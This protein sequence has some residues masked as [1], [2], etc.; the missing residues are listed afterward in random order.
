[1]KTKQILLLVVFIP[2]AIIFASCSFFTTMNAEDASGDAEAIQSMIPG[3]DASLSLYQTPEGTK[4]FGPWAASG[5]PDLTP[6]EYYTTYLSGDFARYPASGYISDYYGTQGYQAY[7]EL[8]TVSDGWGD[9]QVKLYIYPTL[10]PEVDYTVETYRV[11]GDSWD[12]VDSSGNAD[13]T[14]FESIQTV[15]FDGRVETR[16]VE[17]T[18]YVDDMVFK[19]SEFAIPDDPSTLPDPPSSMSA[20]T[21]PAKEAAVSG[22]GQYSSTTVSTIPGTAESGYVSTQAKEFYAELSDGNKYSKSYVFT[23]LTSLGIDSTTSTIRVY[24]EDSSGNKQIRSKSS[25]SFNWGSLSWTTTGTEKIDITVDASGVTTY[26]SIT[27]KTTGSSW[28]Q[29]EITLTE[30]S[31]NSNT[32]SGTETITTSSGGSTTYTLTL[33]MNGL[34]TKDSNGNTVVNYPLSDITANPLIDIYLSSGG[35][36]KGKKIGRIL[37]GIYTSKGGKQATFI[38]SKH[39]LKIISGRSEFVK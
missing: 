23:D 24:M 26:H 2:L 31:A 32:F 13:A 1:M 36:F 39:F 14:A 34:V 9:Y 30:D 35:H 11:K 18:R 16:T 25:G 5:L 22:D 12:L 28:R 27:K 29:T 4:T 8:R 21:E 10:S 38:L 37:K 7:I 33:D 3:L 19:A 6:A 17:W 20:I 15:Y